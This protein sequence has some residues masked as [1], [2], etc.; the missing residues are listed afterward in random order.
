MSNKKFREGSYQT[1]P[2][3]NYLSES[4]TLERGSFR[5]SPPNKKILEEGSYQTSQKNSNSV[6]CEEGSYQTSL[7]NLTQCFDNS[8]GRSI[9]SSLENINF[10]RVRTFTKTNEANNEEKDSHVTMNFSIK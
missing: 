6:N 5:T 1:S 8:K 2:P 9:L 10:P 7:R 3:E 4:E